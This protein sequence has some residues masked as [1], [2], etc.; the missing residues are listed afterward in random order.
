[1][2]K[3]K[4]A[5]NGNAIVPLSEADLVALAGAARSLLVGDFVGT[6]LR[7][8]KGPWF[9]LPA[10]NQRV[11]IGATD[12]FAADVP[13]YACGWLQWLNRKPVQKYIYRPIDGFIL[14]TRDRLPDRDKSKWPLDK[15]GKRSD[16]WQENHQ[17]VMKDLATDE[18]LT[19]T[20]TSWYGRKAIGRLIDLYTREAKSH[21]GLMPVVTLSTKDKSSPDYGLIPAPV[22]T[23]VDW[24][25]F[26]AGA[27]PPGSPATLP[28]ERPRPLLAPPITPIDGETLDDDAG[29]P[30]S[31][32]PGAGIDSGEIPF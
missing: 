9:K 1:M 2:T 6:P 8:V 16:P 14:P 30:D 23:V 13:S 3:V 15:D 27:A 32:N 29:F 7:F 5:E 18:L 22:L 28:L 17:I 24:K 21:A 11:K 10:K 25:A 20:T 19:W 26:G 31:E 12:T 4:D